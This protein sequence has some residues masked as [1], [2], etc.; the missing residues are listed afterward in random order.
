[1]RIN[2]FAPNINFC[3]YKSQ[4][5]EHLE[6]RLAS[7]PNFK[8]DALLTD[9]FKKVFYNHYS[10]EYYIGS[11]SFNKVYKLDDFYVIR[12]PNNY[13]KKKIFFKRP[14]SVYKNRLVPNLSCYYGNV[15]AKFGDIQIL[16]NAFGDKSFVVG[17]VLPLDDYK[18]RLEYF[19]NV[20]LPSFAELPQ[21]AYNNLAKDIKFLNEN[22][23]SYDMINPNNFIKVDDEIRVVDDLT[24][25]AKSISSTTPL[26][27]MLLQNACSFINLKQTDYMHMQTIIKKSIIAMQN[28]D[29]DWNIKNKLS[30]YSD[31]LNSADID[32]SISEIYDAVK[33]LKDE[34]EINRTL[35]KLFSKK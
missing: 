23:Y 18:S 13:D 32:V 27:C 11:G 10:K 26:T 29:L 5:S 35:D 31:V 16:Q 24:N 22:G 34:D 25:S 30:F 4:F 9:D 3:A 8:E 21:T 6:D 15:I 20:Y 14:R 17:G 7:K 28:M 33:D 19:E 2:S 12:I 1:M